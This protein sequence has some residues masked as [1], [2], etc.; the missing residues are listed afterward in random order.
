MGLPRETA[1]TTEMVR[2]AKS[3]KKIMK[4]VESFAV[5]NHT[6]LNT[7]KRYLLCLFVLALF[8]KTRLSHAFHHL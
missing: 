1:V 7:G 3:R 5:F 4:V 8:V 6:T 2:T